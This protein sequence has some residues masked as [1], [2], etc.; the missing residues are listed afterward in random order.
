MKGVEPSAIRNS[1]IQPL[2]IENEIYN[3]ILFFGDSV[4]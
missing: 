3:S 2:V 4:V 1:D